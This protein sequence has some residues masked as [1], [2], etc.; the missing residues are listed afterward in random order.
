MTQV[1]DEATVVLEDPAGGEG[2]SAELAA[3]FALGL[4]LRAYK[5]DRYKTGNKD[6]KKA[7]ALGEVRFSVKGASRSRE[8]D[9]AVELGRRVAESTNWARDLVN[10]PPNVV[11]P[12]RL[13]Q[14]A[15]EVA[16]ETGL[17]VTIGGRRESS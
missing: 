16:K 6:D 8:L 17:K 5:F 15:Q 3:Q 1:G 9:A 7:P 13:A 10:E 2:P 12:E 14:A 11:H 4:V